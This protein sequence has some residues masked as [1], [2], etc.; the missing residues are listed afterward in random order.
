MEKKNRKNYEFIYSGTST[1]GDKEVFKVVFEPR[2]SKGNTHGTLYIDENTLAIIKMEYYPITDKSFW[3]EVVW[4][5][6]YHERNGVY[7]LLRVSYEGTWEEYGK[8]YSYQALL[9]AN[10]T[11]LTKDL[12]EDRELWDEKHSF[13]YNAQEDF[14]DSFWDGY[15]FIKLDLEATETLSRQGLITSSAY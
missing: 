4:V 13:F 11:A 5:E 1:I 2:T 12:P 9:V 3:N 10:K 15:N 8:E 6:E 7:E 14:S